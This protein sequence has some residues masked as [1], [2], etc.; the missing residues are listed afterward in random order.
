[1]TRRVTVFV[2]FPFVPAPVKSVEITLR[3]DTVTCSTTEVYPK[4]TVSLSSDPPAEN[5]LYNHSETQTDEKL[6]VVTS[7]FKIGNINDVFTYN[8]SI[9]NPNDKTLYTAM[10]KQQ[11][12]Q[13]STTVVFVHLTFK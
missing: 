3:N 2:C 6:F 10:L 4:P 13:N 7:E 12:K 11:G 8:C 9:K 1:M 5:P